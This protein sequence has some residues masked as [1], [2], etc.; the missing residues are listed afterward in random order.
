ME[1]DLDGLRVI[2]TGGGAGIGRATA[3]MFASNGAIVHV[4][5]IDRATS[6]FDHPNVH[7]GV[8]DVADTASVDAFMQASMS[9]LGGVDVLVNNAGIAGPGG[10]VE[11]I[12]PDD[13]AHTLDV[14]LISM[15]RTSRHAIPA[16]KAQRS[17]AIVNLASTA[18][19]FGFPNRAPYAAAKWAVIG[20]T[21]TL[22]MELGGF[23]IRCNAI[24]PGSISGPRMDHVVDLEAAATNRTPDEVRAGFVHQVSMRTFIDAAEIAS[25]ICFLASPCGAHISGQSIAVDGNT[26]TLRNR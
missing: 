26:E 5:D 24:C 23:G 17:G 8:A 10:P 19:R 14:D 9:A 6:P 15:F 2:V 12:Q 11:S 16:M 18:G 25:M 22:A 3:E 1:I 4:C 20:L 7:L 13:V 21:E